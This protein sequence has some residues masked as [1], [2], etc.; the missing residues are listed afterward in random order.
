MCCGDPDTQRTPFA[1]TF[2]DEHTAHRVRSIRSLSQFGR[3]FVEPSVS[4]VRL[5]VLEGLAVHPRG[6][7]VGATA[8][9]GEF[10]DVPAIHLVVQPVEPIPRRS[11]RF[12]MQRRPEFLNLRWRCEAHANLPALV[13][14]GT[15]VLNSGPFPPPELPGFGGTTGLSATPIDLACPSRASSRRSRA[16]VVRGFPCCRCLPCADMP[17]PLP[18]WDRRV[19]SLAGRPI[20]AVSLF[21]DDGGLPRYDGGSAPTLSLSRPAQ[22]SLALRPVHSLHR[23]AVHLSRRLR[24]FRYLHRRS[25]SFRPE[26]PS[27]PGGTYTR[28][29]DTAFS[30]RTS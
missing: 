22:H 20:P 4:P 24:R 17:L 21:A 19:R 1:I 2:R 14:L 25:D 23:R 18:R 8:Q 11:L 15:L 7:V 30:R 13:P 9:V 5:D 26:R 12:G 10:Q 28:W 3:Q 16:S 29:V 6:A 27:W